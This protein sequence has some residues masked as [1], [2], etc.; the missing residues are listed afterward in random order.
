[1]RLLKLLLPVVLLAATALTP[2]AAAPAVQADE[3]AARL[4]TIPGL[5]IESS[6]VV[7][8]KP[9]FVLR[10]TQP[11]DHKKPNGAKF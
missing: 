1:M 6:S 3:V 7:G 8:G 4:A 10:Y 11:A 9:F 5:R 2:A